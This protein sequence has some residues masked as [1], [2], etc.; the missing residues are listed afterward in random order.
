MRG[1]F[2]VCEGSACRPKRSSSLTS[3][4]SDSPQACIFAAI[5]SSLMCTTNS[6]LARMFAAV[7]FSRPS[8][9]RLI[10][11]ITIGGSSPSMLNIEKG[12]ALATPLAPS[13][14]TRAIGRGTI[15]LAISL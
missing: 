14:V 8:L 4:G 6:P 7:S 9:S 1:G 11:S 12:A 10:D 2:T 5:A 13:V 15:R 3:G